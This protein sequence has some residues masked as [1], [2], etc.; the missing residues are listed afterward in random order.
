MHFMHTILIET[1]QYETDTHVLAM[2]L[3]C[4]YF[5]II[6]KYAHCM[7]MQLWSALKGFQ[8][9][10]DMNRKGFIDKDNL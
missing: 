6:N 3:F 8:H 2:I 4:I 9:F 10:F 5:T 1:I 7:D